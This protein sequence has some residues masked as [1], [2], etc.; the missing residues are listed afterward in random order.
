MQNDFYSICSGFYKDRFEY[1]QSTTL[2][3]YR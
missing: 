2:Q 3:S 1:I